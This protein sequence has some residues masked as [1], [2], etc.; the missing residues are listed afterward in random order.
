MVKCTNCNSSNLIM[1]LMYGEVY[2]LQQFQLHTFHQAA[3]SD[4]ADISYTKPY[5][6]ITTYEDPE[7]E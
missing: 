1:L 5:F 2:Q 4:C 6:H 7:E 3:I